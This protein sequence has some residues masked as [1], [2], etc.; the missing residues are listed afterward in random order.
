M[1]ARQEKSKSQGGLVLHNDDLIANIEQDR[2]VNSALN[3]KSMLIGQFPQHLEQLFQKNQAN[4]LTRNIVQMAALCGVFLA[5]MCAVFIQ[6]NVS[7][8]AFQVIAPSFA[9]LSLAVL[10]NNSQVMRLHG[11][12][13]IVGFV[14]IVSFS[15][16]Y[17]ALSTPALPARELQMIVALISCAVV[18][19]C[20]LHFVPLTALLVAITLS[21]FNVPDATFSILATLSAV[22][23]LWAWRESQDRE[24]FLRLCL[25]QNMTPTHSKKVNDTQQ[26]RQLVV[27]DKHTGLANSTSFMRFFSNE[28][29]RAFRARQSVSIIL[30]DISCT[31][32]TLTQHG[33]LDH[34]LTELQ[35][36]SRRPGDLVGRISE[37]SFAVLLS[38]T[39]IVNS[40]RLA[41]SLLEH[42]HGLKLGSDGELKVYM[43]VASTLPMPSMTHQD[44]YDKAFEAL[45]SAQTND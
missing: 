43:G 42:L 14:S 12:V 27:L 41:E 29:Q 35:R 26:A 13:Y 4:V 33:Q 38:N 31:V 15:C 45:E 1:N 37:Q 17:L 21:W 32:E 40:R 8:L 24:N 3:G 44:L 7:I 30:I 11:Q 5:L 6:H 25:P 20:P 10:F 16:A 23:A 22:T 28:W 18:A 36:Y 2:F 9:L 39:D 19:R 34:L